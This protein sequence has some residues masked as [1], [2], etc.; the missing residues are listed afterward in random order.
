MPIKVIILLGLILILCFCR[1]KNNVLKQLEFYEWKNLTI[2]EVVDKVLS[3]YS[4]LWMYY[5]DLFWCFQVDKLCYSLSFKLAD[6]QFFFGNDN[7]SELDALVFG[8]LF[9]IF[10]MTTTTTVLSETINK[11][12]NLTEFCYNIEKKYFEKDWN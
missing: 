3:V 5:R 9:C 1:K 2:E 7:P 4:N 12:T 11:Y 6:K 8:H 10:T